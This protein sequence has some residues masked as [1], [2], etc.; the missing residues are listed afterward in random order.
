VLAYA[1]TPGATASLSAGEQIAGAIAPDIASFSSRGPAL[2]GTGDLLKPDIMA[3]GVDVLAAVSPIEGG[4]NFDFLSGTSMSSPHVAGLGALLSDKHP[5]WSPAAQKSALMT[6]ATTKRN[7]GT[8]IPGTPFGYGAGHVVPNKAADPGLV[9]DA[10]FDDWLAFLCGT[11][12]LTASYCPSI[13]K[14][15][16]DLNYPSIAIGALAGQQTVT[17]RVTNVGPAGTYAVSVSPAAGTTL[18]VSP[19]SL[20]L[21]TGET[22]TYTVTITRTTAAL[23]AYAFGSL[24]WSDGTRSVRSPIVVRPVAIS[25]PAEV[26]GTGTSGT[27]SF[28]VSFGYDGTYSAGDHG[29]EA[30]TTNAGT[31]A[32]DPDNTF[33]PN[34]P[35]GTATFDIVVPAGTALARF[36]TFDDAV[37]GNDDL[38]LYVYRNGSLVGSSGGGTS[39]ESVSLVLPPAGTY[40]VFVHAWQSD[41]PD[42]NFTLF[43]WNVAADPTADD[44]SLTVTAPPAAVVGVPGTVQASWS[45]LTAGTRYLG[46]VSHSGPSGLLALTVVSVRG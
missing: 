4:R 43:S 22:A 13:A 27:A 28:D 6:T 14:D 24:S 2:A 26:S 10:G 46:A 16:S 17:R 45:G 5:A 1:A 37:D 36:S 39:A 23:N 21:A 19:S 12:E 3:P 20:T 33:D 44:G 32:D 38:D 41:G 25:A 34:D 29:L 40:R 30:A 35:T 8:D 7:N 18:S 31:V 11:G 9:Y 42:T 15:P